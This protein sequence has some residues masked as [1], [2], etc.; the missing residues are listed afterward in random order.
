M[1]FKPKDIIPLK[2]LSHQITLLIIQ[3]LVEN[4]DSKDITYFKF[5]KGI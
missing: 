5:S 2:I 4:L 1:S 3:E